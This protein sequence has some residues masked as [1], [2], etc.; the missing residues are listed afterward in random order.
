MGDAG[1]GGAGAGAAP[2]Q[3]QAATIVPASTMVEDAFEA[4]LRGYPCLRNEAH[5][6][7]HH[8]LRALRRGADRRDRT[9]VEGERVRLDAVGEDHAPRR[10]VRLELE[11]LARCEEPGDQGRARVLARER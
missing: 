6:S 5:G 4:T 1:A 11:R 3:L 10:H 8:E 7:R 9:G 2:L